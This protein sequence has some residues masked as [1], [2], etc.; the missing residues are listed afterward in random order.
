MAYENQHVIPQAYL[1]HFAD[2]KFVYL[3]ELKNQYNKNIRR[4][5]IGSKVFCDYEKNYYDF[6]NSNNEPVLE[7]LFSKHESDYG[8]IIDRIYTKQHISCETKWLIVDWMLMI[9]TRSTLFR[10]QYSSAFEWIEKTKHGLVHGKEDMMKYTDDFKET[11]KKAGKGIQ[12]SGFLNSINYA[13]LRKSY[14][15]SFL[16][17]HWTVFES[18]NDDFITNDSPGFSISFSPYILRL[19]LS[20]LSS[21]YNLDNKVNSI[22]Y[23]PLSSK[24]CLRLFPIL[25]G[26]L[27]EIS[28]AEM[29]KFVFSNIKYERASKEFIEEFNRNV[30]ETAHKV[31]ISKNELNLRS[32][33]DKAQ[34]IRHSLKP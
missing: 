14:I 2:N 29:R 24:K 9:K 32:C 10:D 28:E 11:G 26:D 23:F 8:K 7:K 25:E 18:E 33:I 31:V 22:H 16:N 12:L 19:G 20:P 30:V 27:P 15:S 34:L 21:K 17:R 4:L 3:V 1:K 13:A 5:G 6:P